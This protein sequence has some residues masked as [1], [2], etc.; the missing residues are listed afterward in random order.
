MV[1]L[2]PSYAMGFYQL[3]EWLHHN[4]DLISGRYYWLGNKQGMKYHMVKWSDLAFP[5]EFGGVGLL[6]LEY[7]TL[8]Y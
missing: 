4:F 8:L 2:Y 1:I 6:K 3:Y 5:K 7:W